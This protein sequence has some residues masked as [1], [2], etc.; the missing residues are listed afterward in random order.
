MSAIRAVTLK[1]VR[2][3]GEIV[4]RNIQLTMDLDSCVDV[5][6]ELRNLFGCVWFWQKDWFMLGYH[7]FFGCGDLYKLDH[8]EID[9]EFEDNRSLF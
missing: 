8:L 4:A 6:E 2:Y 5:M 1:E 9:L 7:I 3:K